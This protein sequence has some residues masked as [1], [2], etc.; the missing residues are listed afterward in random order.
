LKGFNIHEHKLII[1]FQIG[2]NGLSLKPV[3]ILADLFAVDIKAVECHSKQLADHQSRSI[4]ACIISF[5]DSRFRQNFDPDAL[6]FPY[7]KEH[8]PVA[9]LNV[10]S[11]LQIEVVFGLI[12]ARFLHRDRDQVPLE[13]VIVSRYIPVVFLLNELVLIELDLNL[14]ILLPVAHVVALNI[15]EVYDEVELFIG[16]ELRNELLLQEIRT[17]RLL[18]PANCGLGEVDATDSRLEGQVGR[19]KRERVEG[20]RQRIV[21]LK[22][23]H[24][25]RF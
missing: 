14:H 10:F 20:G 23:Q 25:L 3:N 11:F 13:S 6:R 8:R 7:H 17:R 12:R 4:N 21:A 24:I 5:R 1:H 18:I 22:I 9:H 19:D 15:A 2:E 16:V